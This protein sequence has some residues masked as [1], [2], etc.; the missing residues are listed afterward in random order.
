MHPAARLSVTGIAFA[1]PGLAYAGASFLSLF[2]PHQVRAARS[3]WWCPCSSSRCTSGC[4]RTWVAS[5]R[6]L[7]RRRSTQ[8]AVAQKARMHPPASRAYTMDVTSWPFS[9]A[10]LAC[11]AKAAS[12]AGGGPRPLTYGLS[13]LIVT[14][15]YSFMPCADVVLSYTTYAWVCSHEGRFSLQKQQAR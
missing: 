13:E 15:S 3:T 2:Q 8:K 9:G 10:T 4:P 7:R 12:T 5:P 14:S 11:T 1:A 6:Q